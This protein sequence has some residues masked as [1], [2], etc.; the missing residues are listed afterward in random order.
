[1]GRVIIMME[2]GSM[3]APITRTTTWVMIITTTGERT[4]KFSANPSVTAVNDKRELKALAPFSDFLDGLIE[5]CLL[6]YVC[7]QGF[8]RLFYDSL[9]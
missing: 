6:F 5:K 9:S 1:M 8:K 4:L 2:A 7:P 3:K